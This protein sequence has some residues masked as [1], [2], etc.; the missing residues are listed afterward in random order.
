M[1]KLLKVLAYACLLLSLIVGV[2]QRD[3]YISAASLFYVSKS[4]DDLDD[5]LSPLTA[6]ATISAALAKAA[7]GDTIQVT[8]EAY[9]GTGDEALLIMQDIT[10]SGGWD[11]A[12]SVRIGRTIVDGQDSRRVLRI[13]E[14]INVYIEYFIFE[15]GM[16]TATAGGIWND[17]NLTIDNCIVQ[18]N[19]GTTSGGGGVYNEGNLIIQRSTVRNNSGAGIYNWDYAGPLVILNSTINNN[20]NG[21]GVRIYSQDASIINSTIS[22]NYNN[23]Y[24]DDGGGI[25]Y[26]GREENTLLLRNVTITDNRA[27]FSGGGIHIIDGF[28]GQVLISNSIVSENIANVGVDCYGPIL[29]QG[30]NLIG[31]TV[32]CSFSSAPGDQ[33]DVNPKLGPLQDNGGP[34]YTHW[35]YANST[36]I[37]GGNPAGCLDHQD[38]PLTMDQRGFTRPL[39]G[40][41]D[42]NNICDIGAYEADP[43]N[44]PPIYP[45]TVWYVSPSGND[46]NDC[47]SPASPCKTINAALTKAKSYDSVRVSI[48]TY[49]RSTGSEVVW[50]NKSIFISG[51][52]NLDFTIQSSYSTINGQSSWRGI[53]INDQLEAWLERLLVQNGSSPN[54]DGGG[55]YMGYLSKLTLI[56]SIIS[57]STA[58]SYPLLSTNNGGGI[59]MG[60]FGRLTLNNS[61]IIGN[62]ASKG[63]GIY[64]GESTITLNNSIII[65]NSAGI[66]GGISGFNGGQITINHSRIIGNISVNWGGGIDSSD[67]ELIVKNSSISS[68]SAGG[69]GGGIYGHGMTIENSTIND[70]SAS[71]GGGIYTWSE[72]NISDSAIINNTSIGYGGGI[73]T[74]DVLYLINTTI[75]YN[76][77]YNPYNNEAD[78]GGI[79]RAGGYALQA[80]NV[81][82]A[83]NYAQHFGGGI[84]SDNAAI[85]LRNTIIAEN[86]ASSGPDCM[87]IIHTAGYNLIGDTSG[88]TFVPSTG[89][90]TDITAFL[91]L[92]FGMPATITLQ[93]TSPAMDA[94]NPDGCFDNWGNPIIHDQLGTIRPVDGNND[95]S[96]YCDIGAFEYDPS[97]PPQWLYLPIGMR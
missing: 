7:P 81:T 26:G 38:N 88:C 12:F 27:T 36:A 3:I 2:S 44:L 87:G 95:G 4:G 54:A 37:D 6:C 29:S 91:G 17:G 72:V 65:D 75:A 61:L 46:A 34:T 22:G 14:A 42:G 62:S 79:Y 94:G 66:G 5:C 28:E 30:Y 77:A 9:T 97:L 1:N 70:N 40:D 96:S 16:S 85:T 69:A 56:D 92:R 21:V 64:C 13:Y 67:M 52:W 39:D 24:Y 33:L 20:I 90:L 78:G 48:G 10:L 59:G 76:K 35:I 47:L 41:S 63:G 82:I 71:Q 83:R 31:D 89:D 93:S 8:A 15:N 11:Q 25:Y 86:Q 57:A 50:I 18:D 84:L 32:N 19:Q 23:S 43:N 80:S 49:T 74:S 58:G 51:G 60:T 53:T 55:I 73:Y 68:N 45:E